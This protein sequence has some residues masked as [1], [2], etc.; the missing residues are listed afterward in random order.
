MQS[1][2]QENGFYLYVDLINEDCVGK[3]SSGTENI[4]TPFS[5]SNVTQVDLSPLGWD[6]FS[7]IFEEKNRKPRRNSKVFSIFLSE[8]D[9]LTLYEG[10]GIV[11]EEKV[12]TSARENE[13][14]DLKKALDYWIE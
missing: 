5:V 4:R 10:F 2:D 9:H 7:I 3:D 1:N 14:K 11:T 8:T 13:M 6:G 12:L